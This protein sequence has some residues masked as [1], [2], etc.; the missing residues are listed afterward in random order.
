MYTRN[1][2]SLIFLSLQKIY[3]SLVNSLKF[4]RRLRHYFRSDFFDLTF[5]SLI[6]YQVYSIPEFEK[7][8]SFSSINYGKKY[9]NKSV[10]CE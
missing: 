5:K 9:I 1:N 3:A 2:F 7:N 10:K 6:L 4:P 8:L